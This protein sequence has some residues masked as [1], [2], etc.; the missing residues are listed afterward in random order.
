MQGHCKAIKRN[1]PYVFM[2]VIGVQMVYNFF[3]IQSLGG[4]Y[5]C[6]FYYAFWVGSIAPGI[7]MGMD[8]LTLVN[9]MIKKEMPEATESRWWLQALAKFYIFCAFA[10][11]AYIYADQYYQSLYNVQG[12]QFDNMWF[13]YYYDF[14]LVYLPTV[15]LSFK[16]LK[17]NK[18][19]A[20]KAMKA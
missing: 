14:V 19:V 10:F 6:P 12:D 8:S 2:A 17:L 13:R 9:S 4:Q 20:K 7:L 18:K 5:D 11:P 1:S 16:Y 15:L 3:A